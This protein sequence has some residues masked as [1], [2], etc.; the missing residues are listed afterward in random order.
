M[1][2]TLALA[3][4]KRKIIGKRL[5]QLRHE[6]LLPAVVY[7]RAFDPIPVTIDMKAFR[8]VYATAGGN[9][10]IE[11]KIKG[12][13]KPEMTLVRDVQR[14][15][16]TRRILHVDLYR[17][18]M[19]ERITTEVSITLLGESPAT[20][21]ADAMVFTGVSNLQIQC[22]P[23]DLPESIEVDLSTLLEIDQA[24][25]VRDLEIGEG[26][27]VLTDPDE[28]IVRVS[29]VHMEVEEEEEEEELEEGIEGIEGLET[30]EAAAEA[31]TEETPD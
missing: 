30:D 31:A 10:L 7:G 16:V 14:D 29:I 18:S 5:N 24:I 6:G 15:P 25:F 1:E 9:Q 11:V 28:M 20:L 8:H 13:R 21:D 27:T 23:G 22:L 12:I 19:T 2:Q 4:E 3:A 26:I 17:V